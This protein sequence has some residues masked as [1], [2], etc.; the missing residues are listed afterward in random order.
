MDLFQGTFVLYEVPCASCIRS[1]TEL[2]FVT[3]RIQE[4]DA[5]PT[6]FRIKSLIWERVTVGDDEEAL[7]MFWFWEREGKKR[8]HEGRDG[9][10]WGP[11][12]R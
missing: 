11:K 5:F 12:G 2:P 8:S 4:L 6:K 7:I 9:A 3:V 1:L 10:T